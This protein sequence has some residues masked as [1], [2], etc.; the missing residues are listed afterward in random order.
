MRPLQIDFAPRHGV[1]EAGTDKAHRPLWLLTCLAMLIL[2]GVSLTTAW[3]LQRERA[4]VGS[5]VAA[6]QSALDVR[7]EGEAQNDS[8]KAEAA[9]SVQQ[10]NMHLNYPWASMLGTL[11]QSVRPEITLV[12]LEMGVLRQSN[13]FVIESPNAAAAL[14]FMETMRD[15]PAFGSLTL[16]RQ[17]TVAGEGPVRMRFTLDAPVAQAEQTAE[18]PGAK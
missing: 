15:E 2:L 18:K 16:T 13:K 3:K 8:V 7:E 5:R 6:L 14:S 9:Q 17:E 11:E 4:V 10:A 1:L 12:S